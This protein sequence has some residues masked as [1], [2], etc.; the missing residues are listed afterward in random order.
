M[1][2]LAIALT[3]CV[4]TTLM[5]GKMLYKP[6]IKGYCKDDI[7]L[8]VEFKTNRLREGEAQYTLLCNGKEYT[9]DVLITHRYVKVEDKVVKYFTDKLEG[10]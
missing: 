9:G 10:V 6:D 3:S 8:N 4:L 7:S 5:M 1:K 2:T